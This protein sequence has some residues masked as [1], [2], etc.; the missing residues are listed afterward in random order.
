[1]DQFGLVTNATW[2]DLDG[3]ELLDLVVVGEWMPITILMNKN[4]SFNNITES[5]GLTEAAGWYYSVIS[6]DFDGDGDQDL[7]AG[8]LG[9]NYKYKAS[10]DHT[11]EVYSDDLDGN[12][13]NDIV[14]S[15]H[16]HGEIF[17]VRGKSCSSQQVPSL[18]EKVE[19]FNEFANSNIFDLYGSS[20]EN[21]VHLKAY[22][23]A[24]VYIEN[25]GDNKFSLRPLL[26]DAQFS[27]V[28][29]IISKDFNGD[30]VLDIVI[31]GNLYPAEIET[32]R[33]DA[34]MGLYLVGDGKGNFS[35]V[36]ISESGFVAPNDA[37]DMKLINIGSNGRQVILVGNNQDY[38]QAIGFEIRNERKTISMTN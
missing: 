21:A 30:G 38:L 26:N 9:L 25:L 16:E 7:I 29:S 12:G 1:M 5:N 37:K 36:H 20:L 15:Y 32:P 31:S 2:T 18:S 14:L 35:P 8:N 22:N 4:G 10:V 24:S 33:N 6:E 23:F 34:G 17:P 3:D 13:V 19:T 11:F 27:S 28:N